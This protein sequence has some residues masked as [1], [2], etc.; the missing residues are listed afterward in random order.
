MQGVPVQLHVSIRNAP[1]V[2]IPMQREAM[3]DAV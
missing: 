2:G 3:H 1:H